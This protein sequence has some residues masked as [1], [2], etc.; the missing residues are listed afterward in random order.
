MRIAAPAGPHEVRAQR[1]QQ[2][3]HPADVDGGEAP[4]AAGKI[5]LAMIVAGLAEPVFG[6]DREPGEQNRPGP[7]GAHA[8]GGPAAEID[9]ISRRKPGQRHPGPIRLVLDGDDGPQDLAR[10][11]AVDFA[12]FEDQSRRR[13]GESAGPARSRR[14]PRRRTAPAPGLV[15]HPGA[16]RDGAIGLHE[17]DRVD[18][19]FVKTP[20][21]QAGAAENSERDR[22]DLRR[23]FAA[24][25]TRAAERRRKR[26]TEESVLGKRLHLGERSLAG[27]VQRLGAP[28]GEL[29]CRLERWNRSYRV[30]MNRC[31]KPHGPLPRLTPDNVARPRK[32][33]TN[34]DRR[35]RYFVRASRIAPANFAISRV[36]SDTSSGA[37]SRKIA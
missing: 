36:S 12:P 29:G 11:G 23:R 22:Q 19:A 3:L 8:L 9:P 17:P 10:A 13:T 6:G 20:E 32:V 37:Q 25:E 34:L 28:G 18:V 35:T 7:G 16:L 2:R 31:R 15:G 33:P 1:R 14:R 4:G 5:R 30:R 21:R 26:K 24:C 27:F